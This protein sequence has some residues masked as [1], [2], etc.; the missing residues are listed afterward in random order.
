MTQRGRLLTL[1]TVLAFAG[2]LLWTTLSAQRVECSVT[3]VFN[4]TRNSATASASSEADA[5][6]EAQTAACGP[7]A[8][9]MNESIAC[10]RIPPVSRQCRTL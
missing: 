3:V 8:N 1:L 10:G 9:G 2:F 5:T 4:N 6:R 7:I